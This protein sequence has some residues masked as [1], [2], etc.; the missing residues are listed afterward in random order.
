MKAY[1]AGQMDKHYNADV[2]IDDDDV[3]I[4]RREIA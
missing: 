1:T 4:Y 2:S 3:T